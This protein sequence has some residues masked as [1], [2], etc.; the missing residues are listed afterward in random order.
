MD[1]PSMIDDIPVQINNTRERSTFN[2]NIHALE[3]KPLRVKMK[4]EIE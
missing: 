4:K 3:K 2:G 1:S